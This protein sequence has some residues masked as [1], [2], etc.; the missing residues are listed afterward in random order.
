M[1]TYIE[2]GQFEDA[3]DYEASNDT[4]KTSNAH[5]YYFKRANFSIYHYKDTIDTE[6]N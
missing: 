1:G 2:C 5:S 3:H 4:R 6:K